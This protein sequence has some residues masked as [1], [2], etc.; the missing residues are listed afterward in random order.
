[1]A[2]RGPAG[3]GLHVIFLVA[4]T[5]QCS[6]ILEVFLVAIHYWRG[7]FAE[8]ACEVRRYKETLFQWSG[9]SSFLF[10]VKVRRWSIAD[11]LGCLTE[12]RAET[13]LTDF[14]VPER[15]LLVVALAGRGGLPGGSVCGLVLAFA[16]KGVAALLYV[17]F[18]EELFFPWGDSACA[19]CA[20]L[21]TFR[22][23]RL[24]PASRW[25]Q[26]TWCFAMFVLGMLKLRWEKNQPGLLFPDLERPCVQDC[27]DDRQLPAVRG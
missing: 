26:R 5:V 3:R 12:F 18:H 21:A 27:R 7:F 25:W 6:S 11:V 13:R 2:V 4:Y 9:R 22:W 23:L 17:G 19:G 14:V 1:V 8:K 15:V 16:V 10:L 20:S 24:G